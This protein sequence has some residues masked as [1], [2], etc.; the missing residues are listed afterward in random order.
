[1]TNVVL[2]TCS[3]ILVAMPARRN[4]ALN[5]L[6][7]VT[8]LA[9]PAFAALWRLL[10]PAAVQKLE[11]SQRTIAELLEL[12]DRAN[13]VDRLGTIYNAIKHESRRLLAEEQLNQ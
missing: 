1:M 7:F 13:D 5:L 8:I 9:G 6:R 4:I 12:R 3:F 2:S 10:I 11:I